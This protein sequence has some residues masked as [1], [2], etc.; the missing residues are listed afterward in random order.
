MLCRCDS[1]ARGG[2]Y[3]ESPDF[4][5]WRSLEP[6]PRQTWKISTL[7]VDKDEKRERERAVEIR[8]DG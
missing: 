3:H 5:S 8:G 6:A 7:L 1:R 2:E 4:S